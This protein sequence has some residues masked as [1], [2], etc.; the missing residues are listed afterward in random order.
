MDAVRVTQD[1]QVV[2]PPEVLKELDWEPGMELRMRVVDGTLQLI[3]VR[4]PLSLFGRYPGL[5]PFEREEE[6]RV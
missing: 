5:P 1:R 2:V 3:P 6:D 4:Y